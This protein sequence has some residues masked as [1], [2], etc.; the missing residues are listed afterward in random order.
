[1]QPSFSEP[2]SH[3]S[4]EESE[5]QLELLSSNQLESYLVQTKKGVDSLMEG[6]TFSL[7]NEEKTQILLKTLLTTDNSL[8]DALEDYQLFSEKGV[9]IMKELNEEDC[10]NKKKTFFL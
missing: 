10:K 6:L 7:E 4:S 5:T 3:D 2:S 8:P 9:L 1:M